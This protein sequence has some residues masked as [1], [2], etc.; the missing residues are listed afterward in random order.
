M[1][2]QKL[3]KARLIQIL[4]MLSLLIIAF[5]W[6]TATY[7]QQHNVTCNLQQT[8]TFNVKGEQFSVVSKHGVIFVE[9]PNTEWKVTSETKQL[10]L[11]QEESVWQFEQPT[12]SNFVLVLTH[13]QQAEAIKLVLN[14]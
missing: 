11:I 1:A 9:T 2:A 5:F 12:D 7:S 14:Q 13:S 4:V 8:C 3:T 6:R 10:T